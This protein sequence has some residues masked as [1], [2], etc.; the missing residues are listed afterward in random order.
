MLFGSLLPTD[1]FQFNIGEKILIK[2]IAKFVNPKI[3]DSGYKY[4]SSCT[5]KKAKQRTTITSVYGELF[6]EDNS[7]ASQSDLGTAGFLI[8]YTIKR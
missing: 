4:F 8:L 1:N 7:V 3:I 2:E 6:A 5:A